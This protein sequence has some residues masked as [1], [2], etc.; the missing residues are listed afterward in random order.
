[1]SQIRNVTETVFTFHPHVQ[2]AVNKLYIYVIKSQISV[3][4]FTAIYNCITDMCY[5]YT[6]IW[7]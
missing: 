7:K 6:N 2:I 1:M 3:V 5:C 4:P